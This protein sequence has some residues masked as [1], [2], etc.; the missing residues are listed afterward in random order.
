MPGAT[1]RLRMYVIGKRLGVGI[2]A[3]V[4]FLARYFINTALLVVIHILHTQKWAAQHS[5]PLRS[6]KHTMMGEFLNKKY[7]RSK[8]NNVSN[9][10]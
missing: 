7:I 8:Y 1:T 4:I 10:I 6:V 5:A 3:G 2:F 9:N